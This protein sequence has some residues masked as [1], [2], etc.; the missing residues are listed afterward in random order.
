VC[1]KC[2]RATKLED[3]C[4]ILNDGE[5]IR[6]KKC[7]AEWGEK[8]VLITTMMCRGNNT[9]DM[10]FD[11]KSP[12]CGEICWVNLEACPNPECRKEFPNSKTNENY[13]APKCASTDVFLEGDVLFDLE[14][15]KPGQHRWICKTCKSFNPVDVSNCKKES[16]PG[17]QSKGF[18]IIDLPKW[19]HMM[20]TLRGAPYTGLESVPAKNT[21]FHPT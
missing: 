4:W 10:G 17:R 7:Q 14:G 3:W 9:S 11:E 6:C 8:G 19:G 20:N 12:L 21:F 15:D 5:S 18:K 1:G 13:E 16:C 2:I